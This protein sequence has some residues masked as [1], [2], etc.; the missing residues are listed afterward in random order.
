MGSAAP[1]GEAPTR[2]PWSVSGVIV[3]PRTLQPPSTSDQCWSPARHDA[4]QAGATSPRWPVPPLLAFSGGYDHRPA[5]P[6]RPPRRTPGPSTPY[7]ARARPHHLREMCR[8]RRPAGPSPDPSRHYPS[9]WPSFHP[10]GL[11]FHLE[12][13]LNP[14]A[15]APTRPERPPRRAPPDRAL[16]PG[17]AHP[18]TAN[19]QPPRIVCIVSASANAD[20]SEDGSTCQGQ[21]RRTLPTAT[22]TSRWAASGAV[23]RAR[24]RGGR[25]PLRAGVRSGSPAR[26]TSVSTPSAEV[27]Q[28]RAT[29]RGGFSGGRSL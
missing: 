12:S 3:R 6:R 20:Y 1:R 7:A 8:I 17:L 19:W 18:S 23:R 22:I 24:G 16:R 13:P 4:R 10:H 26:T 11:L 14:G 21:V 15:N 29:V 25:R 27:G 9:S 28:G 5:L 2:S